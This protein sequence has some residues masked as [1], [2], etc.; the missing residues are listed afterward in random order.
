[1]GKQEMFVMKLFNSENFNIV[2]CPLC[3]RDAKL[4]ERYDDFNGCIKCGGFGF[5]LREKRVLKK[6]RR[7][8][9]V[10]EGLPVIYS[11]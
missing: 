2:F 6:K 3:N 8:P 9:R 10:R 1:M 4:P 5:V 7:F 11:D